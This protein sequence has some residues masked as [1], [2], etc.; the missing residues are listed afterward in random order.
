MSAPANAAAVTKYAPSKDFRDHQSA[1]I[2]SGGQAPKWAKYHAKMVGEFPSP[3]R[4]E[5]TR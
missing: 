2:T 4:G 5:K 1:T 3:Y